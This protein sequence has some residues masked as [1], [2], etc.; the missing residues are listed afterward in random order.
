ML[1]P[2][3]YYKMACSTPY[4]ANTSHKIMPYR[5]PSPP[6]SVE[7]MARGIKNMDNLFFEILGKLFIESHEPSSPIAAQ[8]K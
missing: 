2:T 1:K 8:L 6:R 3:N 7:E 5:H 4:K